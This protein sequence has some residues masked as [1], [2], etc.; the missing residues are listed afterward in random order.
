[1]SMMMTLLQRLVLLWLLQRDVAISD[2]DVRL[3]PRKRIRVWRGRMRK[4][5]EY[6][7]MTMNEEMLAGKL[8]L[9][10]KRRRRKMEKSKWPT[11]VLTTTVAEMPET[12]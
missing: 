7:E 11:S 3:H 10:K 12:W 2:H 5:M 9:R 1:M 6:S 8:Q 4:T